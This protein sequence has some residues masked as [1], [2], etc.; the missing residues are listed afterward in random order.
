MLNRR[1]FF[2]PALITLGC[3]P[4][5]PAPQELDDLTHFFFVEYDSADELTL[6]DGAR[7]LSA[8]HDRQGHPDGVGG[9]LTPIGGEHREAV[10]LDP[11]VSYDF[12]T[13]VFELA[14]HPGCDAQDLANI[15]L[16][17]NQMEL[18]P[19]N[20][21]SYS[22]PRT[23]NFGCFRDGSCDEASYATS[24]EATQLG[25]T[26]QYGYEVE[27]KRIY[28]EE[29]EPAGIL[30]R[31][32]MPRPSEVDGETDG[33]SFFDQSYTIEVFVDRGEAG[34]LHHYGLWNSGGYDGID[35]DNNIWAQQYL[36]GIEDWNDRMSELCK[37][38]R[39]LW[40]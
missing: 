37:D 25:K 12:I 24:V 18:F 6:V 16:S 13:G 34:S 22:R 17:N 14:E 2:W 39:G 35:P 32:W 26:S 29:G 5:P 20:Y 8:W 7:N 1:L 30:C 27:F 21:D 4:V 38:E 36:K 33:K 31:A 10:G 3:K 19:G 11:D 23:D 9:E 28:D 15:Y 40:N